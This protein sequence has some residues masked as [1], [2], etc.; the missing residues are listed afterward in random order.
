MAQEFQDSGL[1]NQLNTLIRFL[2]Y[3]NDGKIYEKQMEQIE[4]DLF[5]YIKSFYSSYENE[6]ENAIQE[7]E[8]DGENNQFFIEHPNVIPS[9]KVKLGLE[10]VSCSTNTVIKEN[11]THFSKSDGFFYELSLIYS[12]E[13]TNWFN[14]YDLI[15]DI[16][17]TPF[18]HNGNEFNAIKNLKKWLT[19]QEEFTPEVLLSNVKLKKILAK[20]MV[21]DDEFV[22]SIHAFINPNF[23]NRNLLLDVENIMLQLIENIVHQKL[24]IQDFDQNPKSQNQHNQTPDTELISML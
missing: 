2:V 9:L 21:S 20:N 11:A 7:I 6:L 8:K 1:R 23:N 3:K 4:K 13:L 17:E 5:G 18:T 16:T 15:S 12:E 24:A 14:D 22:A 19:A 10:N